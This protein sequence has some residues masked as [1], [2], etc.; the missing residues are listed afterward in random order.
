MIVTRRWNAHASAMVFLRCLPLLLGLPLIAHATKP[1]QVLWQNYND[2]AAGKCRTVSLTDD[3]VLA[4]APAVS[5]LANLGAE[6]AWSVVAEADGSVLVGTA[7]EG[8]LLR[9]GPDGT[10]KQ[11]AKFDESHLYAM[12][13]GPHGEIY[14]GTSPDGK[15]YQVS[16]EGKTKVYFD[17]QEKYIWA[18]AVAPD[19]TL[20]VGTGTKGKIYRVSASGTGELWYTSNETHIRA[21]AVDKD[22]TLLAGSAGSGYLYRVTG[23]E[24]AIVLAATGH[25]EVNQINVRPDGLIYFTATGA[26]KEAAAGAPLKKAAGDDAAGK[27]DSISALFRLNSALV[28]EVVWSTKDTILSLAWDDQ[29]GGAILG[30]G[31]DGYSYAVTPHGEA[32]RLCRIDSDSVTAMAAAGSD[33]ILASSNPGRL[34]R[35]GREKSQPGVYETEVVDSESFSRWGA[36]TVDASD[37]GE[38]KILTR[39]GNTFSPDKTWYPWMEATGGQVRSAASRYLQVQVEIGSGT[40][41]K[42]GLWFLPK[43]QPPHIDTVK[44]LPVGTGYTA[45]PAAPLPPLPQS[46]NQLLSGGDAPDAP[47]PMRWQ[48]ENAHGLRTVIWKASDPNGDALAY[49]VSWRKQGEKEWHD[50]AKNSADNLLSWDTSS[51]SDGRYE[52]QITASDAAANAPGE[53]LIDEAISREIIVNNTP[54]SIQIGSQKSDT[55][56]F[57]VTDPLSALHS[58]TVSTDGKS[59]AP[60][61]PADGILDSG[62]ER[63]TAKIAPGQTLFIRAEDSAGNVAGAQ[64]G[65]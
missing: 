21:L 38:V 3:G 60:L 62:S 59:F 56:E 15:V 40:V 24:Q 33:T 63:F 52:L 58:V 11:L 25:E 28:P 45:A 2:L 53:G 10:V 65:K 42:I 27:D 35:I 54:P 36:V 46:A 17:P 6:E 50:L 14:V 61:A 29:Q 8:K 64:T 1:Q 30:T 47:P 39:S 22:G 55:V 4:A 41:D 13:R 19:G 5:V 18:L 48:I 51:W 44:I 20:Y 31:T 23:Q 57:T 43:N 12:A 32:T 16:A 34:F 9:V 49:T 37:S 7:P 26:G